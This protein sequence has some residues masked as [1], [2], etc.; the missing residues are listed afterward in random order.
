[1]GKIRE[2]FAVQEFFYYGANIMAAAGGG[3]ICQY[4]PQVALNTAAAIAVLPVL[5]AF[6]DSIQ[7]ERS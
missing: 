4:L 2:Y 3:A 6:L 7:A 5:C 1:M